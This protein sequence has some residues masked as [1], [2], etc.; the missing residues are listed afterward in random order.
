MIKIPAT[1]EG[2]PAIEHMIYEGVNINVTLIF[3][4]ERYRA[5]AEAFIRGLELRAREGQPVRDIASVASFFVSRVDTMI[6]KQLDEKIAATTDA[7]QADELRSLR[8]K[9]AIANARV[10][11]DAYKNIFHG[12]RFAA[13]AAQGA[14]PQRCLWAS[15]STKNPAY[16]DVLYVEELIGPET[17]DTMP[18]QTIVAFQDHGEARRSIDA[19]DISAS[20]ELLRRLAAAGIDMDVVT[21]QLELDGVKSFADSYNELIKS[22]TGK[23]Q[24]LRAEVQSPGAA[25]TSAPTPVVS[26]ASG[27]P[28][29]GRIGHGVA[30]RAAIA[31]GCG[32]ASGR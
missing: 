21:H 13:L 31:G 7:Q 15:T 18:P 8:G 6:D 11:Y 16:R 32:A 19:E 17:V 24:R 1:L 3:S 14:M 10:A 23:A 22:T 29:Y 5:V 2:L 20:N 26:A 28:S 4:L 30:R 25:S 12:D 27:A 9:A